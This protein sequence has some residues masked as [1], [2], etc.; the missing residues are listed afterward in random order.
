MSSRHID[1][2]ELIA[3]QP[4]WFVRSQSPHHEVE[5]WRLPHRC[6]TAEHAYAHA[7]GSRR[8]T[9]KYSPKTVAAPPSAGRILDHDRERVI[10]MAVQRESLIARW[11][12]MIVRGASLFHEVDAQLALAPD[13]HD[14]KAV[15]MIIVRKDDVAGGADTDSPPLQATSSVAVTTHA[16]RRQAHGRATRRGLR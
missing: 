5:W 7:R 16:S 3:Y 10:R 11:H 12:V 9:G 14:G 8:L 4:W 2:N 6:A 1:P 15:P 13:R